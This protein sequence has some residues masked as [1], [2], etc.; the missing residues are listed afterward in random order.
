MLDTTR[1]GVP[2]PQKLAGELIARTL[3]TLNTWKIQMNLLIRDIQLLSN[4][5]SF[6]LGIDNTR[7]SLW[8]LLHFRDLKIKHY[9]IYYQRNTG[10]HQRKCTVYPKKWLEKPLNTTGELL[11]HLYS[12][13]YDIHYL[14]IEFTSGWV[15]KEQPQ[16]GF[17]IYFFH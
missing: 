2:L 5:K 1:T 4:H 10:V 16:T 11:D 8:L 17:N 15:I 3:T 7:S 14:Q 6:L 9:K 13:F 12:K